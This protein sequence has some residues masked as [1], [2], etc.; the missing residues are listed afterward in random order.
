MATVYYPMAYCDQAVFFTLTTQ[1]FCQVSNCTFMTKSHAFAPPMC[2]DF[3]SCRVPCDE[4]RRRIEGFDLSPELKLN[5]I[6]PFDEYRKL[7][8]GG[9]GI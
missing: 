9:A 4:S 7:D 6:R 3:R 1:E 5:L 8:A 2:T